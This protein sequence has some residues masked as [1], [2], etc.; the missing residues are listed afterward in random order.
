[1]T[2]DS[3][4]P[5]LSVV[6]PTFQRCDVV[7]ESVRALAQQDY[8]GA[9]EVIVVVDGSADGSANALR[10]LDTPFPLKVVEQPNQ[11]PAATRNRGAAEARGTLLLF[12]DDDMEAHPSLLSEHERSHREGADVVVGHLP[13]HPDSPQNFLTAG[14]AAW[15][16]ERGRRLAAQGELGLRD[17]ISGQMSVSKELFWQIGGFDAGFTRGGAFGNEDLDFGRRLA[18]AG[19]RIAFNPQAVSRQ[20][21]V[22]TPRR[23]L[24]Q[25]RE[26]GR[27]AVLLARKH[28]DQLEAVFAGRRPRRLDRVLLRWLRPAMRAGVL[29]LAQIAPRARTTAR[30]FFRLRLL[31]YQRGVREGGGIPAPRPVRVLCYHSVSDLAGAPVM[32]SYGMRPSDF[33]AQIAFLERHFRFV[34][35]EEFVRFAAEGQGVPRRAVL[36][37]FDDCYEDLVTAALPVLRKRGIPGFAFAVTR[38]L[39]QTNDWDRPL[40]ALQIRLMT[41]DHLRELAA[42]GVTVGSHTRTHRMLDRVPADDMVDELAGSLADLES[43]QIPYCAAL[44]YPHGAYDERVRQVA[45]SSGY[46]VAFTVRPGRVCP[47]D[48]PLAVRRIEVLRSDRGARFW[49]KVM[50][51]GRPLPRRPRLRRAA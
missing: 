14:V 6:V 19:S 23:Y 9:F 10:E 45:R 33:V 46:R 2:G 30:L 34:S 43:L 27:S 50:M 1:V 40:G 16:E 20:R 13:L 31:E 17:L 15:A 38:R 11:G 48:D 28:P 5:D 3:R 21:Y 41:A 22:V 37:T 47:G 7:V 49:W 51:A 4:S 25:W 24:R 39:G 44:S 8:A 18:A 36:L 29:A 12:L 26:A 35:A 42:A 32:E